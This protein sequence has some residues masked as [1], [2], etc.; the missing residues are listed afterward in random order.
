[1][2]LVVATNNKNKLL[3][4]RRIL[5]PIGIEV[6]SQKEVGVQVAPEE[7][8]DSF[9]ANARIKAQAVYAAC[10]LPC[11]ADD[12]GLC[13]DALDGRPGIYSARY[14]GEDTAQEVKN[15]ALLKEL[16]GV[17]ME[18]R[19]AQFVSAL[20]CILSA[21]EVLECEGVCRGHIGLKAQGSE[22]FGYDP[23]FYVGTKSYAQL[24]GEEKD[25]CSH[26]GAALKQLYDMLKRKFDEK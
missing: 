16:E 23:I 19:G 8:G 20:C 9:A 25:A 22:G 4:F 7:N 21:E 12:S 26:R 1:M 3:E 17:P 13:V 6:L 14:M 15:A 2:K 10:G 11:V 24:S 18:S 5:E